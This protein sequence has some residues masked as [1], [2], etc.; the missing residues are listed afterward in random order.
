[1]LKDSDLALDWQAERNPPLK[2]SSRDTA[3]ASELA[4]AIEVP[5]PRDAALA[6]D[7]ASAIHSVKVGARP[8]PFFMFS[9]KVEAL[10]SAALLADAT[11]SRADVH[12]SGRWQVC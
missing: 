9:A 2:L 11:G 8:L 7:G 10:A 6:S 4:P 5:P 12:E 3:S 1:M